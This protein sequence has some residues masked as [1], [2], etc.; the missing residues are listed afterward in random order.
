MEESFLSAIQ[1]H[2]FN[3]VRHTE[4]HTAE[5]LVSVLSAL[6]V[7]IATE[8]LKNTNHQVLIKSQKN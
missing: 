2:C 4:I 5:A 1:L 8:E 7:E 3:N 6:E